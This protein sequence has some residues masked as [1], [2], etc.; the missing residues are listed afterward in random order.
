MESGSFDISQAVSEVMEPFN[1]QLVISRD[2]VER[3]ENC[4]IGHLFACGGMAGSR[5]WVADVQSATGMDVSAWNPFEGYAAADGA[6]PEEL[7]GQ[8]SRFAAAVGSCL[9]SFE[10]E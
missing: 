8:E 9:A 5:D 4:R 6:V 7:A 1:K 3:R 10:E 2:F